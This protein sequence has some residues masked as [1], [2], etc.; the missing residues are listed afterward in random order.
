MSNEQ[1]GCVN[2]THGDVGEL[3]VLV[4]DDCAEDCCPTG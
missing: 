2:S 4:G 1:Q 3:A